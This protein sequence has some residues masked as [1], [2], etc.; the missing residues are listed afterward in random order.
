M[1]FIFHT[2]EIY[3]FVDTY[4]KNSPIALLL[5]I[6][7]LGQLRKLIM[8][9]LKINIL[10]VILHVSFEFLNV[11]TPISLLLT[12]KRNAMYPSRNSYSYT[13]SITRINSFADWGLKNNTDSF[14]KDTLLMYFKK[15]T[16]KCKSSTLWSHYSM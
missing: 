4:F 15:L 16:Q 11:T 10:T 12:A 5:L 13:P 9:S 14:Y 6:S 1:N 2:R 8:T 3:I 7:L